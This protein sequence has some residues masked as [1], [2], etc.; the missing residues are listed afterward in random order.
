MTA[1]YDGHESIATNEV[2]VT[3]SNVAPD[4]VMLISPGDGL[5][6]SVDST[7]LD[8]E[9][10]FIWTAAVDNDNDPVEYFPSCLCR[11][12]YWRYPMEHTS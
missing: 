5:E 6:V 3:L 12:G 1:Q 2:E 7:N 11:N 8:E 4:A 9:V 10:A